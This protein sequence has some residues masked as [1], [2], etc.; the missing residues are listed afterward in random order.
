[1]AF[2]IEYRF[3]EQ[4]PWSG[5]FH[6]LIK[7]HLDEKGRLICRH[8]HGTDT[9][10]WLESFT[11]SLGRC[12]NDPEKKAQCIVRYLSMPA[13]GSWLEKGFHS[14]SVEPLYIRILADCYAM[15][16]KMPGIAGMVPFGF[17][18]VLPLTETRADEDWPLDIPNYLEKRFSKAKEILSERPDLRSFAL[19]VEKV[20]EASHEWSRN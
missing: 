13:L 10:L 8:C 16:R 18:V 12:G 7:N 1:M 2:D 5:N 14:R 15:L 3:C 4:Y 20:V 6:G 9:C 17:L 11:E 19:V